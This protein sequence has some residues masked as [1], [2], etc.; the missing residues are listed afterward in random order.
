M[1]SD[2]GHRAREDPSEPITVR[3]EHDERGGWSVAMPNRRNRV[4]CETFDD[5]RRVAYLCAAHTRPCELIVHDAYY[6]VLHRELI[7]GHHGPRPSPPATTAT[8]NTH[9]GGQ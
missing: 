7:N 3:V 6:R 1:S 4:T 9:R 5:A 8:Q 2:A